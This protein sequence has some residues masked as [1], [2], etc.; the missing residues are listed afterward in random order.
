MKTSSPLFQRRMAALAGVALLVL[1]ALASA[2]HTLDVDTAAAGGVATLTGATPA[3]GADVLHSNVTL[4]AWTV[5]GNNVAFK[6]DVTAKAVAV[7]MC[8]PGSGGNLEWLNQ[9]YSTKGATATEMSWAAPTTTSAP[10]QTS[11]TCTKSDLTSV[12][13]GNGN[14]RNRTT[15]STTVV[16]ATTYLLDLSFSTSLNSAACDVSGK[17]DHTYTR[18][19]TIKKS[20]TTRTDTTTTVESRANASGPWTQVS[21]STVQGTPS[22]ASVSSVG[23]GT[24][25]IWNPASAVPEPSSVAL[26]LAGALGLAGMHFQR[27]SRSRT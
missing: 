23:T 20:V 8:K 11:Q 16:T 7:K 12:A 19:Y 1:P 13:C 27:R 17:E 24:Y 21:S 10:T 3:G 26:L 22:S 5:D 9:G 6:G 14:A 15:V 2:D 4:T 18:G 25:A